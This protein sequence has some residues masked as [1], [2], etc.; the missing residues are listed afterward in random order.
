L[1]ESCLFITRGYE[2]CYMKSRRHVY[3]HC[4]QWRV[5][6]LLTMTC[7][8]T[9]Y[10][11]VYEQWRVWTLH[12]M[13]C[14]NTAYNDMYEHCLQWRVWTMPT[15]DL[16]EHCLQWR[17]WTVY[18]DVYEHC[19]QWR[20]WTM[21]T[22]TCMNTAY[23][24]VYEHC[25]QWRVWTLHVM[26]CM[27]SAYNDVYEH[28]LQWHIALLIMH[29]VGLKVNHKPKLFLYWCPNLHSYK[30]ICVHFTVSNSMFMKLINNYHPI[31][32]TLLVMYIGL[33]I[34]RSSA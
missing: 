14:M 6:T 25:L 15:N 19:L 3:E 28:C 21:F 24:D 4:L 8:N 10:N 12:T 1:H 22:M 2:S 27:N 30:F 17:V 13:T 34:G 29:V 7:M 5:W 33:F 26:T 20:V 32:I 16:Y 23:N 18:N 11:D 31:T 9:A